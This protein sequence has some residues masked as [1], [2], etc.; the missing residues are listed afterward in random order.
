[1]RMETVRGE[2]VQRVPI[3]SLERALPLIA[4]IFV[5]ACALPGY[6]LNDG[7]E[8]SPWFKG[9]PR[10]EEEEA[11]DYEPSVTRITPSLIAEMEEARAQTPEPQLP[12]EAEPYRYRVGPGDVLNVIV[13][14]HPEL[15]NPAGTSE[16]GGSAAGRVVSAEGK[17]FFPFVGEIEVA[18][19][20]LD[21]IRKM[22]SEGLSRV[23]KEPQV[24]VRVTSFR[25]RR[26]YITG[27]I[28]RPCSVPVTDLPL[29]IMSALEAC[30]NISS[31]V[32]VVELKLLRGDEIYPIDLHRLYRS[33]NQF[34]L[35]DGDRLIVDNTQSR[36]FIVGEFQSQTVE[37][38]TGDGMTLADAIAAGG[39]IQL[40]TADPGAIYVIRGF[41]D[42]EAM[43]KGRFGTVKRPHLFH[44]NAESV[45]TLVLADQFELQ[46]RDIVY[47]A[48]AG[49]VS[50][51]RALA[52]LIP[53]LNQLF[54][55]Y[56]IYDRVRDDR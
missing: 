52:Q 36:V 40:Q 33:G 26:V 42:E 18:G 25:S 29:T 24:D 3:K 2:A 34:Q 30:G 44:L 4:A 11:V 5:T 46:P 41:I 28:P 7:G 55:T 53:P 10:A 31:E 48:P 15:T 32:G 37:P 16:A 45:D 22:L 39:G 56:F 6:E 49:L 23:I 9:D 21:Q 20:T 50:F 51:N 43:D 1:M 13:F 14:N 8:R 54:Q 47:A 17:I 27:D 19:K 38:L 12:R 35:R